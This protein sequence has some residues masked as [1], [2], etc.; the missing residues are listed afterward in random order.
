MRFSVKSPPAAKTWRAFLVLV[1]GLAAALDVRAQSKGYRPPP[2]YLQLGQP[3]QEEGRRIVAEFRQ[4]GLATG[5]F[6]L[7]FDLHVMPR[8]G[9]ERLQHGQMWGTRNDQGALTR[10]VLKDEAGSER[11]LLVQNGPQPAIWSW[12]AGGAGTRPLGLAEQ[13]QPLAQTDLTPFDLQMPFLFW[14]DFTFEGMARLRG[15]PAHR[16]L[17]L[18]PAATAAAN[19]ALTGVRVSLDAQFHALVETELIGEGGHPTKTISLLE[20]KKV[21]E[22]WMV[23]TID[24]RDEATHNKTR[25]TI[26]GA[27]LGLNFSPALF[28]PAALADDVQPPAAGRIERFGQ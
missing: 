8:R 26:T 16:F 19:P 22:Q 5:D 15:R 21:Q 1:A 28:E 27:A 3:D 17:F 10:V 4:M 25:L 12:Q 13:F 20:L 11:R 6:Y 7:E 23:K 18:P 2:E 9:P 14:A 24:L